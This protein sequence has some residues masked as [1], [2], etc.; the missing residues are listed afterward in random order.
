MVKEG[1]AWYRMGERDR[2]SPLFISFCAT[3]E[4][5]KSVKIPSRARKRELEPD[6]RPCITR[7]SNR[8]RAPN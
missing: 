3:K 1:P 8:P 6:G 5:E 4:M 7:A 2:K